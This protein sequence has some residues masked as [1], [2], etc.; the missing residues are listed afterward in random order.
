[1]RRIAA[2]MVAAALLLATAGVGASEASPTVDKRQQTEAGYQPPPITW[3]ACDDERFTQWGMACGTL[4]VPL[5]YS[6]PRGAKIRLA[7]SKLPHRSS[8]KDYQGIMLV[9]PG[10]PGGSGLSLAVLGI[11]SIIPGNGDDDYDWI[12][13]D[14]RGVGDSEPALSC[15]S[16]Y[17][18]Y[19]RPNYVPTTGKIERAWLTKSARYAA[20][21]RRSEARRLLGHMT[22]RDTV[23]DMDSLRRALGQK[24]INFYGFSY[25][26]YLAQTY[27]SLHPNQVRRF[28]MDGN[29]DPRGVWYEDNLGQNHAFETTINVWFGW[30][31]KHN[32]VFGLGD[33]ADVVAAGY[34]RQLAELD[35]SPALGV[36]GPSELNDVLVGAGYYVYDWVGLGEAYAALVNENDPT[37]IK[38]YYDDANPQTEG[39]DNGYAVYLGVQCTDAAWPQRWSQFRLDSWRSFA[40][41]PFLTWNNTWFNAPCLSWPAKSGKPI[42]VDGRK[43]SSKILL[44]SETLDPATPYAGSLE[45]RRLFPSASLIEGVG[46]TTHSG[47]LSGVECTDNAIGAY[48]EDGTVPT[49][50]PGNRSDLQCPPVPQPDPTADARVRQ[51]TPDRDQQIRDLLRKTL[52]D[53]QR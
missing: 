48:L 6:K 46:G 5:D 2:M 38:A 36:I 47:S 4:T 53:A 41:A 25:G 27:A 12:G 17:F 45:V 9:N 7:V 13:F 42:K 52:E 28:V 11:G 32:D 21:C 3:R 8:A 35:K 15:D 23:A 44:I 34:Y 40:T 49:R 33:N 39:S 51:Q 24:Q 30:L 26:T 31:A 16:G 43:V 22:T 20:D 37:L 14:P 29:V 10:G 50:R 1:M 19:N 18:G